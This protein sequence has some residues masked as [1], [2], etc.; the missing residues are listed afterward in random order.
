MRFS[1]DGVPERDRTCQLR[2]F[3]GRELTRYDLEP[4]S[5]VPLAVDLEFQELPGLM[6]MSGTEHGFRAART[7]ESVAADATDDVALVVNLSGPL[8][9]ARPRQDLVLGDGEAVLVSLADVYEF[10]HRP[11]GGVTAL[12]IPRGQIAPLVKGLDDLCY[13]RISDT[14]PAVRFLLDYLKLLSSDQHSAD[15]LLQHLFAR[16][17]YE[18][19]ALAVGATRDV[20]ETSRAGGL[21]AARLHAIKQDVVKNLDQP[22][23]SVKA[24]AT[25]HALTP[26]LVQ[27]LFETEGTTFTDYVLGERLARAHRILNDPRREGEKI[28][29]VAWDC[30]FGD[31]SHFNHVFRR[32]FGVVPSDVRAQARRTVQ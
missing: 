26:R 4:V 27:R 29:V 20:E 30:G 22:D 21:R 3:L 8:R 17:V 18:L 19:M 11:P 16:H 5:D 24:I 13:R 25:R 15:G 32:R 7:R 2:E 12:R 31:I 1:L 10:S 14:V 28:S 6:M 9:L 23:L